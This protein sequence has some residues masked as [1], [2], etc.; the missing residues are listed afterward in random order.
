MAAA[1]GSCEFTNNPLLHLTVENTSPLHFY[2]AQEVHVDLGIAQSYIDYY[3]LAASGIIDLFDPP[4]MSNELPIFVEDTSQRSKPK[5][6]VVYLALA[7]GAQ[8]RAQEEADDLM[9]ERCFAY[10][11]QIA[12]FTLVDDASLLTVQAFILITYYMIAA[13][14]RNAAFVS[15]GI[16]IRTAYTLGIHL[17]E[18]NVAF[19]P[20]EG[21]AR[22]RAWK[23]LRVCDLFLAASLGRPP[24]TSEYLSTIPLEPSE[25]VSD[26]EN[27]DVASQVSS[28]MFR[29]CHCFERILVEVYAKKAVT[30]ELARSISK[31]H[32]QWT[33]ELPRMLKIDRLD[34]TD[35]LP[36]SGL[37][38]QSGS[39]I[40]TM[41]Y[42]WSIVLLTR[43]F[44]AYRVR[45]SS[46][47]GSH[48]SHHS[49]ADVDLNT[50]AH[51]CVNSAI[52]GIDIAYEY[53][54]E[55][56]TPK[57]QPLVTNSVFVS[58]LCLGMA[59][60]D[61]YDHQRWPLGSSVERAIAI[62][63]HLGNLDPQAARCVEICRQLRDACAVYVNKRDET[64]HRSNSQMV[65]DVF[66]DLRAS[67]EPRTV[68]TDNSNPG[69][70]PLDP[71]S[72]VRSNDATFDLVSPTSFDSSVL[73][74]QSL[75]P[76]SGFMPG[77]MPD[78]QRDLLH[79][80][81]TGTFAQ[82][83]TPNDTLDSINGYLFE[84]DIPLFSITNDMITGIDIWQ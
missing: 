61:D 1:V 82:Y 22:E 15:L 71:L 51:A 79:D 43:P 40:V 55:K 56:H 10:G 72:L 48:K 73:Q 35:T 27:L 25:A 62:L 59:Y 28:A 53:V 81:G 41:A 78:V 58:A 54:F 76:T 7:V 70:T 30:L 31:Q 20:D 19:V 57:R 77:H 68:G 14:R 5:S 8:A 2:N 39:S 26:R 3:F 38:L 36:S 50:F 49:Q 83:C 80:H 16:A 69:K 11:R 45:R 4:W 42:Y 75:I 17:H 23:S 18:T 29:I 12:M 24:A 46:T 21:V 47:K 63:T 44:L 74:Q 34:S 37:S 65:Q 60:L 32:R 6:A 13:C 33:Q 67:A 84:Q 64:L 66:G 9:A 52:A